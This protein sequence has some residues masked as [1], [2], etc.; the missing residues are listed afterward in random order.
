MKVSQKSHKSLSIVSQKSHKSLPKVSQKSL[1]SV[2]KVSQKSLKSLSKVSQKSLNW[3]QKSDRLTHLQ[4]HLLSCPGQ[5]ITLIYFHNFRVSVSL[6]PMYA[7]VSWSQKEDRLTFVQTIY[8]TKIDKDN[9]VWALFIAPRVLAY[10]ALQEG[11][12]RTSLVQ[13]CDYTFLLRAL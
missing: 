9:L 5:L 3:N 8:K 6:T 12:I 11:I 13:C 1:K 7:N 2:S 4:G 10:W